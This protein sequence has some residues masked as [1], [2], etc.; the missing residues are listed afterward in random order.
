MCRNVSTES[1]LDV[2]KNLL[3]FQ[4]QGYM[5]DTYLVCEDGVIRV[6]GVVWSAASAIMH[7]V[8]LQQGAQLEHI[9][10]FPG[11]VVSLMDIAV[12]FAYTGDIVLTQQ[13]SSVAGLCTVL[14]ILSEL[15]LISS[16]PQLGRYSVFSFV[17]VVVWSL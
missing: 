12:Q 11:V 14:Q 5:C 17:V 9:L 16:I 1:K 2:R 7:S 6:H 15:G 10:V 8:L 13:Y 4:R 3:R